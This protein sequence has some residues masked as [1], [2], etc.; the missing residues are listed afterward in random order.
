MDRDHYLGI[1]EGRCRNR[2][3]GAEWQAVA[4]HQELDRGLDRQRALAAMTL[5]YC[6]LMHTGA[7]VH[8]WPRER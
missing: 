2:M 1:I 3:N 7:P 5:R 8:E 6:E 4:F